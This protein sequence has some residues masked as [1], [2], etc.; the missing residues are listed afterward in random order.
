MRYFCAR[1][2]VIWVVFVIIVFILSCAPRA[3]RWGLPQHEYIYQTPEKI[4]DG[5]GTSGLEAEGVEKENFLFRHILSMT[6]GIDWDEQTYSYLNSANDMYQARR[7]NDS[8]RYIS[9]ITKIE[10]TP[11]L[12]GYYLPIT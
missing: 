2:K 7:S 1:K 3:G 11:I 5:W 10:Q 6:A 4:D 12:F 9:S 8:I